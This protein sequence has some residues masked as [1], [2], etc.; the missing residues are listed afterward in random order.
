MKKQQSKFYDYY[1]RLR[2]ASM[3]DNNSC[4]SFE[5]KELLK[6]ANDLNNHY[7]VYFTD[8]GEPYV[9]SK[10]VP[11]VK[12]RTYPGK[13]YYNV[14]F[15]EVA[16]SD[17]SHIDIRY[18]STK[19]T[20]YNHELKEEIRHLLIEILQDNLDNIAV[21]VKR[22]QVYWNKVPRETLTCKTIESL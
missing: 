11:Y 15:H 12:V 13:E 21:N 5:E 19:K 9:T 4:L 3:A 8:R 2:N 6:H 20:S 18:H 14:Y 17:I 16:N 22:E 1:T 7:D 10:G